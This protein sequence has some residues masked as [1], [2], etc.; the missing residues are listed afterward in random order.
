MW[1]IRNWKWINENRIKKRKWIT[2]IKIGKWTKNKIRK[3]KEKIG[4]KELYNGKK[5]KIKE[6]IM[7]SY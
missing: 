3:R 4:K 5:L 2:A 1:S 7:R 6:I